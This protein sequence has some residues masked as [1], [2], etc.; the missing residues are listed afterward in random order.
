MGAS[1][2]LSRKLNP[3]QAEKMILSGEIFS[4]QQLF[5]MGLIDVLCEDGE[6][7]AAVRKYISENSRRHAVHHALSRVR[8]RVM[9]LTLEELKDVTDIWVDTALQ[10]SPDGAAPHAAPD[11]RSAS[12]PGR[13]GSI[14]SCLTSERPLLPTSV[15]P[16]GRFPQT[17]RGNRRGDA[18]ALAHSVELA[19]NKKEILLSVAP[20][21]L[22][23]MHLARRGT[24]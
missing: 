19:A 13:N 20:R 23:A 21:D 15:V 17:G 18:K 24:S 8:R 16:L 14:R 12:A 5:D 2:F 4:A 10:L 9:P 6:G 22:V 1:S 11:D 7:E 3:V